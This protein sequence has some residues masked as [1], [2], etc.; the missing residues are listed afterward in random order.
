MLLRDVM[1]PGIADIPPQ[2]TLAEAAQRM[3][4]LDVGALPVCDNDRLVGMITDRDITVRAVANG[5]DPRNTPVEHAMSADVFY[6]YEDE[7]VESAAKLME[8][9]QIR[10]LPI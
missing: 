2:A 9:K 1:T 4:S 10:R 5:C 7:P 3:K 6:C 8:E